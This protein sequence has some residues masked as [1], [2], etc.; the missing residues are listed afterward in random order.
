MDRELRLNSVDRYVKSSPHF[1]LEEHGHCEV[2]AGCGGV[3][4]RWRDP[5]A[6]VPVRLQL[7][8]GSAEERRVELDGARLQSGRPL[9]APGRHVLT[10]A[11]VAGPG[12]IQ[13]LFSAHADIAG[14]PLVLVSQPAPSWRWSNV[15]PS[16]AA[17]TAV[18]FDD[19]SW[20]P[21]TSGELTAEESDSYPV[22]RLLE[23]DAAPLTAVVPSGRL[24]I[25]TVL[26]VPAER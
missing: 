17:W 23:V 20:S 10:I 3:V 26:V 11:A 13:L 22:K 15:E 24:W 19:T 6:A 9:L 8:I 1:V 7:W 16:A 4:L 5:A 21:M 14:N 12:P 2:P 25:R 18:D